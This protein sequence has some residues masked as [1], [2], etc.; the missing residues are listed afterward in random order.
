MEFISNKNFK[1]FDK[2]KNKIFERS[3]EEIIS[4]IHGSL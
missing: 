1:E 3:Y 2:N 4:N